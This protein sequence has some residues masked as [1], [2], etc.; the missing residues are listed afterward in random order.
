M[1]QKKFF[2]FFFL[3]LLNQLNFVSAEMEEISNTLEIK[4][5]P[6]KSSYSVNCQAISNNEIKILVSGSAYANHNLI[7][8]Y[9]LKGEEINPQPIILT[10]SMNLSPNVVNNINY[11]HKNLAA[12]YYEYQLKVDY[13]DAN[14]SDEFYTTTCRIMLSTLLPS[15]SDFKVF[16]LSPTQL[17]LTWKDNVTS[18]DQYGFCLKRLRLTPLK[19]KNVN[20]NNNTI[21]WQNDS[22]L[23][24]IGPFYHKLILSSDDNIIEDS[25]DYVGFDH[26]VASSTSPTDNKTNFSYNFNKPIR[27][28][29]IWACSFAVFDFNFDG[30][31]D[32]ICSDFVEVGVANPQTYKF[33]NNFL[34]NVLEFFDNLLLNFK[35]FYQSIIAKIKAQDIVDVLNYF[36]SSRAID[37]TNRL[38]NRGIL[39]VYK[40]N[41]LESDT[42]YY[43][44]LK[45]APYN[46][47]GLDCNST[48]SSIYNGG[49]TTKANNQTKEI[50]LCTQNSFCEKVTGYQLI[51]SDELINQCNVNADCKNVGS[52]RRIYQ[53]INR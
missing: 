34:A 45:V 27:A 8:S 46:D 36:N 26:S 42:V 48:F 23:N 17:H 12:G 38:L 7:L 24:N 31:D 22:N 5:Y 18:T 25:D 3:F 15:P 13:L 21:T 6:L 47:N 9:I 16:P 44:Q 49:K 33:K 29:R 11:I 10:S 50:K 1:R 39:G 37:L 43:Y 53:E 52:S 40:D 19:P 30:Q 35:N 28:A 51:G 14:L 20:I 32:E 41:N 2:I 4:T